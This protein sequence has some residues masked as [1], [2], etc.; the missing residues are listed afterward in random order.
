MR[1]VLVALCAAV[2]FVSPALLAKGKRGSAHRAAP[3]T[4]TVCLQK[5][6]DANEFAITDN[7]KSYGLKSDSVKLADH[8]GHKVTV[9][10]TPYKE[11]AKKTATGTAGKE[12]S[13]HL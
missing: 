1:L 6:D 4:V 12:E 11:H 9:T 13:E 2:L 5:E 3:E 7:G 8:L 10:G